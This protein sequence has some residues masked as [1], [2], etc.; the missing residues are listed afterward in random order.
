MSPLF[1]QTRL[2]FLKANQKRFTG[3]GE[4]NNHRIASASLE[5]FRDLFVEFST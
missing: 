1:F 4:A 3:W 5:E 2:R